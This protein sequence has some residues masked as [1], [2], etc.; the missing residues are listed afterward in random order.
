MGNLFSEHS[1]SRKQWKRTIMEK[2]QIGIKQ[3]RKNSKKIPSK[4]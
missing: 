4:N 3:I 2:C 1:L